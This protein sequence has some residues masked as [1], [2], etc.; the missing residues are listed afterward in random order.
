MFSFCRPTFVPSSPNPPDKYFSPILILT[1]WVLIIGICVVIVVSSSSFKNFKAL[2]SILVWLSRGF[3]W[4]A[5]CINL[6]SSFSVNKF[7]TLFICDWEI[8]GLI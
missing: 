2:F 1:F 8:L 3:P 4:P 7:L 5:V 6:T